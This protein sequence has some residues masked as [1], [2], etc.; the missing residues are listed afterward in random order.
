[1]TR[2]ITSDPLLSCDSDL[3]DAC[4]RDAILTWERIYD[5]SEAIC[6]PFPKSDDGKKRKAYHRDQI[7]LKWNKSDGLTLAKIRDKWNKLTDFQRRMHCPRWWNRI[8]GGKNGSDVVKKGL[9]KAK[10]GK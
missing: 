4:L 9:K 2:H 3:I 7:W 6:A 8:D 5:A 1:M 10:N